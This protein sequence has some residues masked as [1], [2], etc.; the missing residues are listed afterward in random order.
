MMYLGMSLSKDLYLFFGLFFLYRI[1]AAATE[2]VAKA[3]ISNIVDTKD[4][5]TAIGT[6]AGFQSICILIA[7]S[8]TGVIWYRFGS[9]AALLVTASA[10]LLVVLY[11][12]LIGKIRTHETTPLEEI[13]SPVLSKQN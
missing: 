13:A 3:W 7:S 5:A 9:A 10:A 6:F 12:L 11:F 4:T 8:L 1:Y 2:G